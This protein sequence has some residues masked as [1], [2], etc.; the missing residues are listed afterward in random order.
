MTEPSYNEIAAAVARHAA[1]NPAHQGTWRPFCDSQPAFRKATVA[2]VELTE[3]H[4]MPELAYGRGGH[5][6]SSPSTVTALRFDAWM[7]RCDNGAV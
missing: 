1:S 6:I 4:S 3:Y 5:C 7:E 2:G